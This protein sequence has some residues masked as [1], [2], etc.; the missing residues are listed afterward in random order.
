[1]E[2][3]ECW[4]KRIGEKNYFFYIH[5]CS[6]NCLIEYMKIAKYILVSGLSSFFYDLLVAE[7]AYTYSIHFID[8]LRQGNFF[9]I[10]FPYQKE[11]D[12]K[13]IEIFEKVFGNKNFWNNLSDNTVQ[14]AVNMTIT[15][16]Q[17]KAESVSSM[18][19]DI[20]EAMLSHK[21]FV[22][23]DDIIQSLSRV[24][25]NMKRRILE[26]SMTGDSQ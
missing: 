7:E 13:L 21:E 19:R 11:D 16:Y 22:T 25:N 5:K 4:T 3:D 18:S 26:R 1:M 23:Y 9:L 17:L 12:K 2:K 8:F 10:Y 6:S 24:S 15:E 20:I 14:R